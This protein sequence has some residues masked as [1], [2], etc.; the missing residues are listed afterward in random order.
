VAAS[1]H[2]DV[3][4]GRVQPVRQDDVRLVD[5]GALDAVGGDRAGQVSVLAHILRREPHR[6]LPLAASA[7]LPHEHVAVV[8]D[9]LH[10]PGLPVG[11]PNLGIVLT[12]LDHVADPDGQSVAAGGGAG[13]VD[14]PALDP[15]GTDALV[16][17][18][19]LVVARRRDRIPSLGVAGDHAAQV[20][21]GLVQ[22]HEPESVEPVEQGSRVLAPAEL[23]GEVGVAGVSEAVQGAHVVQGRGELGSEVEDPAAADR[24]EL[25]RSPTSARVAP[26]SSATVSSARA[27]S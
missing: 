23:E 6:G 18:P 2:A 5:G 4:P 25:C 27:M 15:F 26:C 19:G 10:S 13:V 14:L 20:F 9:A 7:G 24:G 21:L 3:D 12:G 17:H 1:G 16:Q 11:D 8:G 22:G